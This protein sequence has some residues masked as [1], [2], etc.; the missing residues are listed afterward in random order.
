MLFLSCH[1]LLPSLRAHSY[2]LNVVARVVL[3]FGL[4]LKLHL[5][6]L[7]ICN[8][9]MDSNLI[10]KYFMIAEGKQMCRV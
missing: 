4:G 6:I 1:L 9:L 3:L 10:S 2:I 5:V 7:L 8:R